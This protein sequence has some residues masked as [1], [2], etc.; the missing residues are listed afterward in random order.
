M[1]FF[2]VKPEIQQ[3]LAIFVP[4]IA[5]ALSL[6]VVYP[7]WGRYGALNQQIARQRDDLEKLKAEPPPV[8]PGLV[9][10]TA[11]DVPSEPPE[12]L[13]EI[14]S[15]AAEANCHL[16]G[17][18][19]SPSDKSVAVGAVR[20]VRAK[21]D[22]EAN[23]VQIRDFLFRL[24]HAGR[25]LAVTDLTLISA[26]TGPRGTAP[27]GPLHATLNIERYVAPPAAKT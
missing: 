12:F 26:D 21:I 20:A 25:L 3:R 16:A 14:R 10:P 9:A 24:N 7:A 1:G 22:L 23:Y 13:G 4:L 2:A 27:S 18:D 11:D 15:L 19:L 5:L 6:F 8:A 17:F